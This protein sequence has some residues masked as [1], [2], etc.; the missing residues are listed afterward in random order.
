MGSTKFIHSGQDKQLVASALRY[1]QVNIV[2]VLLP[3]IFPVCTIKLQKSLRGTRKLVIF[4]LSHV[5]DYLCNYYFDFAT[6]VLLSMSV[7]T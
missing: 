2:V 3:N 4:N 1:R 7:G 6:Y 5:E